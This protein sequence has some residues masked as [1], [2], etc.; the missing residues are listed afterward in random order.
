M[1]WDTIQL[2]KLMTSVIDIHMDECQ[3]HNVN[4]KKQVIKEG[5]SILLNYI[6]YLGKLKKKCNL[7]ISVLMG[8]V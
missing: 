8:K 7:E 2:G 5:C 6:S 3:K 1:P 4:Q